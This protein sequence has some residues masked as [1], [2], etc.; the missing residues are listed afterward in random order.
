VGEVNFIDWKSKDRRM[1]YYI[2]RDLNEYGPYTLAD[3]Q[4]YVAQGNIVMSD[5]ARSEGMTDWAPVS[6]ILGTIAVPVP[7]PATPPAATGT[8][9]SGTPAG[10]GTVYSGVPAVTPGYG[11]APAYGPAPTISGPVPPDFHWALVLVIGLFVGIFSLVWLFIEASFVK[12]IRPQSN[13]LGFLIGAI[14]CQFGSVFVFIVAIAVMAANNIHEPPVVPFMLFG[15]AILAGIV[16][17]IVGIFKMRSA[18]EEY[19]NTVEPINLR[20]SGVMTF[21]F[22]VFYFQYHFYRI[23]Q[24]KKTGYLQPQG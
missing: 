1:R 11:A 2:K 7:A 3:L 21:F 15:A 24:W 23:V 19:Y 18:I 22:A 8:A 5:L 14:C 16:L 10:A 20:L 17:H 9:Y 12:K 13:H 4:R 6:Q